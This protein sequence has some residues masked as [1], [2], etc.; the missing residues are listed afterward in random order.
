MEPPPIPTVQAV[1][2]GDGWALTGH[3]GLRRRSRAGR[4][5]PRSGPDR[6]GP[7]HR[8]P[9][10]PRA[11]PACS[12]RR[13]SR[14]PASPSA[15]SP[16]DGVA[17]GPDDVLGGVGDGRGD[18]AVD[19]RP[20]HRRDL[21]HPGRRVR[22]GRHD[23]RALRVRA[24]AVRHQA[25][26]VPGRRPPDRRR[27]HRHRGHPAHGPAG[28]LAAR[29]RSRRPRR[30]DGRQVLGRRGR[31]ARRPRRPAPARRDRDGPRLP[32]PPV[33]PVG[34]GARAHPRRG[35]PVAGPA[36]R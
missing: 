26:H 7:G 28:H 29:R 36:R 3:Q 11:R 6:R 5:H 24:R 12:S 17:V 25:R 20:P 21:R 14:S 23:H 9:R 33:L 34:Q 35:Q 1:P 27:L 10:E 16:F 2:D 22:G 18:R 13:S 31:P 8:L 32:D 15:P 4:R 30:A 19:H